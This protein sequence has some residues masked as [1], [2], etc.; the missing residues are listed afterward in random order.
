MRSREQAKTSN[1]RQA[2]AVDEAIGRQIRKRRRMLGISQL[3]LANAVGIASQQI[4]KYEIGA[5][6][7][8][9][10][11]LVEIATALEA[12]VVWFFQSLET[13][14]VA[15]GALPGRGKRPPSATTSTAGKS[16]TIISL[17][18]SLAKRGGRRG[19]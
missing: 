2:T 16:R 4:Q 7:L 3:E 17:S 10:S 15:T 8:S 1:P 18:D 19:D 14:S 12:P 6:R 5:N 9:V 11:R 13:E